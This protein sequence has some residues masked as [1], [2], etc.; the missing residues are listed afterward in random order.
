[1]TSK[2]EINNRNCNFYLYL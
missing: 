1:M 2:L